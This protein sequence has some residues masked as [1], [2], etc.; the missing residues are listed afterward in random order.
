MLALI[1]FDN[2]P[3]VGCFAFSHVPSIWDQRYVYVFPLT[4]D[5][6]LNPSRSEPS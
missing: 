5:D 6:W 2:N 1:V 3:V 4:S